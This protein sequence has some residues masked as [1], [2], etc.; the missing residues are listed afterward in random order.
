VHAA[1]HFLDL[2]RLDF[3]IEGVERLAEFAVYGFARLGPFDED[4]E[5]VALPAEGLDQ[6]AILLQPFA[7]LEGFLGLGRVVP[8][9]GRGGARL[10]TG[11]LVLRAGGFKDSPADRR[12]VG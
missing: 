12:R 10:E 7:A 1:E 11:Q 6:I 2:R 4:R 3:L 9:I 8:E 5:V